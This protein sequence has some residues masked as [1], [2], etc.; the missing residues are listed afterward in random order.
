MKIKPINWLDRILLKYKFYQTNLSLGDR[1]ELVAERF[2]IRQGMKII[3]HSMENDFGEIDL[4]AADKR[5]IVFVEVKTRR[6]DLAGIPAEA[7]DERKQ[8]KITSA[9]L[10]YLKKHDLLEHESRFD[11]ISIIWSD[12]DEL[13]EIDYFANAFDAVG[14]ARMFG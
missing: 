3:E 8:A 12:S 13:P 2:L 11:V 9:A 4:I 14:S 10:A 7:V 5:T 1:G 6:S